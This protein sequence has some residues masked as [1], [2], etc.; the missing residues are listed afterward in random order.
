MSTNA[1]QKTEPRLLPDNFEH[2]RVAVVHD[3]LT[4]YG[5]AERVLEQILALLP[6]AEL[7]S[8]IDFVPADQRGFLWAV[9]S[10]PR[11]CSV[12]RWPD[13]CIGISCR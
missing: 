3:W 13:S 1:L 7:F 11:S 12:C 4:V 6:H 5:G 10:R 8:L 9:R 2:L